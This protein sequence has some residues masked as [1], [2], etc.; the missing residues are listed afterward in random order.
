VAP[1]DQDRSRERCVQRHRRLRVV[2]GCVLTVCLAATVARPTGG[3][4]NT[5]APP[6]P[7]SSWPE[8]LQQNAH[9]DQVR[10]VAFS[11][12]GKV[13][14]SASSDLTVKL[15]EAASGALLRTLRGHSQR[16]ESVAFDGDGKRLVSLGADHA[17]K[18]W[19]VEKGGLLRSIEVD[20][21]SSRAAFGS[22]STTVFAVGRQAIVRWDTATGTVRSRRKIDSGNLSSI[23]LS[24]D[25]RLLATAGDRVR[26]WSPALDKGA[27]TLDQGADCLAFAP[28]G[29]LFTA[30][31][32]SVLTWDPGGGRLL[33]RMNVAG[34]AP[35]AFDRSVSAMAFVGSDKKIQLWDLAG[36]RAR[37][38]YAGHGGRFGWVHD[39]RFSPDGRLLAS[40]GED[41]AVKLW[42]TGQ[43]GLERSLESH[44]DPIEAVAFSPDGRT[45]AAGGQGR[46]ASID[47][48]DRVSGAPARRLNGTAPP[49]LPP[50]PEEEKVARM[51]EDSL[52][53]VDGAAFT[54]TGVT[55]KWEGSRPVGS[56][57]AKVMAG[58]VANLRPLAYSPDGSRLAAGTL[59]RYVDLWQPDSG[60]RIRTLTAHDGAVRSITF[61][62]AGRWFATGGEDHLIKI[63]DAKTHYILQE[64]ADAHSGPLLSLA[65]SP[66]G[67]LLASSGQ[68]DRDV[69]VW[70]TGNWKLR[71]RLADAG[72]SY[73]LV[74]S[75]DSRLLV[76][77]NVSVSVWDMDSGKQDRT[78]ARLTRGIECAAFS[79]DGGTL[80]VG[81][82]PMSIALLDF[83]AGTVKRTLTG[84]AGPVWS[85]QFSP[86]GKLLASGSDDTSVAVWEVESGR[87]LATMN[88]LDNGQDWLVTAPDG[89]FDGSPGA[90]RQ[91]RWR[92]SDNLF[93]TAPV[94][95]FFSEFYY[96]G[97]LAEVLRGERPAAPRDIAQLDRRQPTLTL[98]AAG[99]AA[100]DVSQRMVA[101]RID[102]AEAPADGQHP[103]GSGA[104][105]LRLFRNGSLVRVWHGDVLAEKGHASLEVA[106]PVVAGLNRFTAYA[107]NRDNIK[108]DDAELALTGAGNLRRKG[109]AYI[110][111]IG[112]DRYANPDYGLKYAVADS[113]ALVASLAEQQ[114]S[115]NNYD[116]V[117]VIALQDEAATKENIL[118]V[119]ARL[120]PGATTGAPDVSGV[121]AAQPED[122]IFIYYAGHGTAAGPRFY[123]I[124]HDLGYD[125][126]RGELEEA[127]LRSILAH[128]ISDRELERAL[129][130]VDAR[131]VLVIDAC[132]S[133][134]ALEAEEKRRGP[135][136]SRG[137]AQL[138]YEKGMYILTAAQ[139]YQA[140]LEVA[141]LG[142]GYLTYALVE[143]GI[144]TAAADTRPRD[145]Q[146]AL[147]EWLDYASLRVPQLQQSTMAEAH[148][149]G[150]EL[151][152]VAGEET[153]SDPARRSLQRPRV[154]YRREAEARPLVI[155]KP[156]S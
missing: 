130:G 136:N 91:V 17:L 77:G 117:K 118:A 98:A 25:G 51:L 103:A 24:P 27:R 4:A 44:A 11:P 119:L 132:N 90:F 67:K 106:V 102:V 6:A 127:G 80:A 29:R 35:C 81:T 137:L 16:V 152:V 149:A 70:S 22:E 153:I 100:V 73:A 30:G 134:Q 86:D 48:W 68:E 109:T 49:D 144:K 58:Y 128:A 12:D 87:R 26:V 92:F 121:Q 148:K 7:P 52:R 55:T 75:P 60:G 142:H 45:L 37:R 72:A 28:D 96:P 93:D 82:P 1:A 69:K 3:Q 89:L 78:L 156:P 76:A 94:E 71:Y 122:A 143:E 146:V 145:G 14:A 124:P 138:A 104:R 97:L 114:R 111:A 2:C 84:H 53:K 39:L 61:D 66:D 135:M 99:T 65:V 33:D 47:L 74:F 120:A 56:T 108:S 147:R 50:G 155:A 140:A 88:S 38:T 36:P 15:W 18:V 110:V 133:G 85:V 113:R 95:L 107:F 141:Q 23:A 21:G 59:T 105:D 150:R 101:I 115:L 31:E 8:L 34:G 123:L 20:E 125:G 40:A 154:F 41:R 42:R 43:D 46:A 112:I 63:W 13:L 79:P 64:L 126:K 57:L 32:G 5:G 129:E 19:D 9:T 83:A 151:A 131:I 10:A 62:P 116:Q 54:I 139:G